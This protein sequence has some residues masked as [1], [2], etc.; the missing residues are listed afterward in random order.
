M[1]YERDLVF[2]QI[3]IA[4][5]EHPELS[6]GG[7]AKLCG[8]S[9]RTLESIVSERTGCAFRSL[10]EEA[11]M[12]AVRRLL[13]QRPTLAIKEISYAMGYKSPRSFARAVRRTCGLTPRQLRLRAGRVL[14][15]GS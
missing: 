3:H 2:A 10:R 9:V 8:V 15:P 12:A 6:L 5:S 4:V 1:S 11:M 7:I 14:I 13:E